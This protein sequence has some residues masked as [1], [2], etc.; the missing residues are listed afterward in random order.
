MLTYELYIPTPRTR[1]TPRPEL[2]FFHRRQKRR[3]GSLDPQRKDAANRPPPSSSGYGMRSAHSRILPST[4]Q[5]WMESIRHGI[6]TDLS[7]GCRGLCFLVSMAVGGGGG[8]VGGVHCAQEI[9][10]NWLGTVRFE[11]TWGGYWTPR[12]IGRRKIGTQRSPMTTKMM[13]TKTEGGSGGSD[14]GGP[15]ILLWLH[16]LGRRWSGRKNSP[17]RRRR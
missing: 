14:G 12:N 3:W 2:S 10:W 15:G 1:P 11:G 6:G 4:A 7:R 9:A 8:G 16:Q 13:K 17:P 5:I